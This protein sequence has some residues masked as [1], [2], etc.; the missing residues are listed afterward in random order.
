M[1]TGLIETVGLVTRMEP[2]AGGAQLEIYAPD[3]GRDLAIGDSVAVN[4]SCL[5][6]VSFDRGGFA[7]D[8]SSE[9]IDKT[10]V[11]HMRTGSKVNL[12]R[13]MRL[14]DRMGGHMVSG[15]IDGVGEL[16]QRHVS[17]NSTAYQFA[18]PE[19]LTAYV[20]DKGSISIDGISL[21]VARLKGNMVALSVIP[22]TEASTTLGEMPIGA[23]VNIEVDLIGKYVYRAMS[24]YMGDQPD[25]AAGD[26]RRL[27]DKFRDFMEG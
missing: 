23:P 16:V 19:E 18:I 22:H 11:R 9:T 3:F 12:E 20:I 8:V 15:H 10:T 7:V 24:A 13:A 26:D 5:T 27:R 25:T 4:G 1:F 2:V 21:T 14:S 6:I 17:G